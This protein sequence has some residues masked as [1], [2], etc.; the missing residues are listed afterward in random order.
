VNKSPITLARESGILDVADQIS[1]RDIRSHLE[2]NIYLLEAWQI[3]S[4]DKRTIGGYFL[5][6]NNSESV[7]GAI[8]SKGQTVFKKQFDTEID[9]ASEYILRKV[10]D[11]LGQEIKLLN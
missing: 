8:D 7:V 11:I 10:F 1:V 6:L 2:K 3:W 9:A 4:E 5:S